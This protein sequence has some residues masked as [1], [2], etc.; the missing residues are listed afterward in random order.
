VPKSYS[1]FFSDSLK[2][3]LALFEFGIISQEDT[4]LVFIDDELYIQAILHMS[5]D[6]LSMDSISQFNSNSDDI[7]EIKETRDLRILKK[8]NKLI[9]IDFG[10][11]N[12]KGDRPI[13]LY[14][15]DFKT[16]KTL[17][18]NSSSSVTQWD[19]NLQ[20]VA[21]K[22]TRKIAKSIK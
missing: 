8:K 7:K 5:Q 18:I 4:V 11:K 17:V 6:I 14:C 10:P 15:R 13:E 12:F 19:D 16:K 2:E 3:E 1:H 9:I 20:R 21:R 22:M